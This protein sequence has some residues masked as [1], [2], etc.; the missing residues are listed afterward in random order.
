[1][2]IIIVPVC[3]CCRTLSVNERLFKLHPC[4]LFQISSSPPDAK[5]DGCRQPLSPEEGADARVAV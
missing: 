5:H 4:F 1:M 2:P 3:V